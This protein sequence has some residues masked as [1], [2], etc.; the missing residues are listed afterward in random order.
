MDSTSE[1]L[2]IRL[3]ERATER[4]W[5]RFTAIYYPLIFGWS[6]ASGLQNADAEDLTQEVL[7]TL[8]RKMRYFEYDRNA[9]FRAWLKTVTLNH[10]RDRLKRRAH[11]QLP[12]LRVEH[13]PQAN[14]NQISELIDREYACAVTHQAMELIKKDFSEKS[15]RACWE[16]AV[17]QRAASDVAAELG[18]TQGSVY[19]ASARVLAKLRQE[20]KG[21]LDD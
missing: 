19:A 6:M 1:S 8:I 4:D 3:R 16:F 7:A 2:L 12:E 10:F 11:R 21:L 20:L 18:M 14:E 5:E 17:L 15:W 9:S 13:D